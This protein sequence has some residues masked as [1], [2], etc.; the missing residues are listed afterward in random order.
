VKKGFLCLLGLSLSSLAS[1]QDSSVCKPT[2]PIEN[3]EQAWCAA[4]SVLRMQSC[5]SRYGFERRTQDLGEFWILESTDK[6][7]DSK[8]ACLK[9][10]IKIRKASGEIVE[11]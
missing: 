8:S 1:S 5:A 9:S 6:N 3:E 10:A 7:P 4:A 11:R 2:A